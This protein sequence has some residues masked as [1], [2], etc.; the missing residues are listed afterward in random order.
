MK[1]KDKLE[2]GIIGLGRV[3]SLLEED[4]LRAKPCTHAGF[5]NEHPETS[6]V[7][8]AEIKEK[9]RK[10][11]KDMW[12]ASAVYEDY[13]DMLAGQSLDI[14]SV[15]AYATDRAQMVIDAA[16]AGVR[17]I[18]CEK[19]VA[20]SLEEARKMVEICRQH[21]VVALVNHSRRWKSAYIEAGRRIE[22]GDIGD[23]ESIVA[24]FS[25]NLLH[26]G[27]HA[28]DVMRMLFGEVTEVRGR[29]DPPDESADKSSGYEAGEDVELGDLGGWATLRFENG[30]IGT[31][32][33]SAKD[34]FVFSF[35]ITGRSGQIKL[36]NDIKPTIFT[37][38]PSKKASGFDIVEP[39]PLE[40][41]PPK[42]K[43]PQ[44]DDLVS[45]LKTG[46]QPRSSL[47]DGLKALEIALA[48][49]A[50]HLDGGRSVSLPL[51]KSDLRVASR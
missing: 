26:T 41:E 29:L 21:K 49:H 25:G 1:N 2:V 11:F 12:G 39:Y 13:R 5:Y 16:R 35:D 36:G 15:C 42:S 14:V 17:G 7:A 20:T 40:I 51:D 30:A 23:P 32:H 34:Y 47:E 3:A 18:W 6:I 46:D 31:V 9:R 45:C 48:I 43:I 27:T 50:S 38:V 44:V 24:T 28:F 33:G 8:G 22:A 10:R 37:P 19:A 4:P